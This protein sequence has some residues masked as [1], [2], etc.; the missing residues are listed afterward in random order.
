LPPLIIPRAAMRTLGLALLAVSSSFVGAARLPFQSAI[1]AARLPPPRCVASSAGSDVSL[2]LPIVAAPSPEVEKA[3]AA[4][5]AA[6]APKAASAALGKKLGKGEVHGL[7]LVIGLSHKTATVEVREKLSIQEKDWNQA[8]AAL[9]AYDTIQEAA[10]LSTCNRFEVYIVATDLF[11]ATRDVLHFLRAHSGLESAELR[12][13]L[14]MLQD[15]EATMHLLRV[16]SGLDSLVVGEGQIL[17]QV[18]AC[19]THAIAPADDEAGRPAGSAGKVLGRLLNSAVMAGKFVRAET[20]IAKGAVSISS[21]AVELAVMKT[22]DDLGVPLAEARVCVIGAGKM[23]KLLLTH[24]ESH[25]VSTVK[26]LNRGR[27][28]AEELAS[29]YPDMDI[30]IGLMDEQWES[31]R[32]CD[33]AFTSTSA[34]GCIV[35]KRELVEKGW[36]EAGAGRLAIIDISVPRNVESECNELASVRAYNVDD[37]KQVVAKNQARRREKVLEAEVLLRDK[38]AEFVSW[39]QSLKYVPAISQLQAKYEAVR[40]AE[41]AKAAKKLKGLSDKD[42]QAV[43]VLTKGILNKLLHAPMSYLRSEDPDGT[44]ASVRQVNEMFQTGDPTN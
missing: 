32:Q 18:K 24:L 20:E 39:Q 37:L 16:S 34:T 13:N 41:V 28:R 9:A 22:P 27:A 23:S 15:E 19:Y 31:L 4:A 42:M 35:T 43:E 17:S 5:E 6:V 44:K 12:P 40:A 25:G 8:A 11:A 21:A 3:R 10:V 38:L 29:L 26:L 14:F 7:P 2:A 30:T 1:R 36:G 33:L